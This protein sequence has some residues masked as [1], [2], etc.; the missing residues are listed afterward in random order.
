MR[1]L[2]S[3]GYSLFAI[4]FSVALSTLGY[5]TTAI[6]G[7]ITTAL[8]GNLLGTYLISIYA[9][10]WGRRRTLAV[11]ALLMM[12]TGIIFGITHDYP[13]LLITVL[14]GPIGIAASE[15][16]PFLPIE[17]AMLSQIT[18]PDERVH[19]FAWYNIV[20]MGAA[21]LG[22]LSVGLPHQLA[23]IGIP[24][25][26]QLFAPFGIYACIGI[27]VF[28][29][30]L[31]LSAQVE[32]PIHQVRPSLAGIRQL[33][34]ILGK[35]RP[36]VIQLAALFGM[37]A[38]AG[39]FIIQSIFA[40]YFHIRYGVSLD[41]LGVVF[42][43]ANV[44]SALSF[45]AAVPLARKIGLLNTMVFTHLPSNL[46]LIAL[47]FAPAFP[48]AIGILV[49]RQALSQMDVPTRQAY[50]MAIVRPESRLATAGITLLARSAGAAISPFAA[51]VLLGGGSLFIGLPLLISG[52]VK[53]AYDLIIWRLFRTVP[54]RDE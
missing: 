26:W 32:A 45:L 10:R 3:F 13:I 44:S 49:M 12:A 24:A 29:L 4:S 16:A 17:Q 50:T 35:D 15:T 18:R 25:S 33:L 22:A 54:L 8:I 41:V 47:A 5:S 43:L 39:G 48:V 46:M 38:F 23:K 27:I 30:V 9:D 11:L 14:L 28:M 2:R 42:F 31:R 21:A 37:D 20:S 1:G 51:S 7:L 36:I 52:S 19:R 6:G 40:L 34:P 53:V